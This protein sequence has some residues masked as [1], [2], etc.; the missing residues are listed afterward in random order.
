MDE[1]NVTQRREDAKKEG[2]AWISL[3]AL[4]SLRLISLRSQAIDEMPFPD[5][6]S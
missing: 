1:V 5:L 4:A 6:K 2:R 3:C